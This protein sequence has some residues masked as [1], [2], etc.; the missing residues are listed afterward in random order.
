MENMHSTIKN[1][2]VSEVEKAKK[3][4]RGEKNRARQD[5]IARPEPY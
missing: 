5:R 1:I 4:I 3:T 2:V